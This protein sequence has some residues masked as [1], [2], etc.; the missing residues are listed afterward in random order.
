MGDERGQTRSLTTRTLGTSVACQPDV[1]A[2]PSM[3]TEALDGPG[4]RPG[5]GA[6]EVSEICLCP[7]VA[8]RQMAEAD[9]GG[10]LDCSFLGGQM[11]EDRH[12]GLG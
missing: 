8:P 6:A 1:F 9:G 3:C 10:Q 12:V 4:L 7:W 2:P 5:A 11:H